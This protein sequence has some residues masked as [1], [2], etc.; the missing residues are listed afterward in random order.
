[1]SPTLV[2]AEE[3]LINQ[4]PFKVGDV[5]SVYI[6]CRNNFD[7]A[8]ILYGSQEHLSCVI[9]YC[10]PITIIDIQAEKNHI[11]GIY[12]DIFQ[13]KPNVMTFIGKVDNVIL[14]TNPNIDSKTV[15]SKSYR[16]ITWEA[17]LSPGEHNIEVSISYT[18]A[19][20]S[21]IVTLTKQI[22]IEKPPE[23]TVLGIIPLWIFNY[24]IIP[25]III[26]IIY[27]VWK[28]YN[29]YQDRKWEKEMGYR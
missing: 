5:F 6:R 25:I 28:G 19:D 10:D 13:V 16:T 26:V 18:G 24:I 14:D 29:W 23:P 9:M 15:D 17:K 2:Q 3:P 1:M 4:T 11:S 12:E 20:N 27:S 21:T 7:G 8:Q 22:K